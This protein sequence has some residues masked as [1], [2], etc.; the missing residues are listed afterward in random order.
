VYDRSIHYVKNK[1]NARFRGLVELVI[2]FKRMRFLSALKVYVPGGT[3]AI[4]ASVSFNKAITS[5]N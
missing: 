1:R 5:T 4:A 3:G 2:L